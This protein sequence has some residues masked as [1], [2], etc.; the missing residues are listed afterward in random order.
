MTP[1]PHPRESINNPT[2]G[3]V[4]TYNGHDARSAEKIS[5]L[6]SLLLFTTTTA[7]TFLLQPPIMAIATCS[8]QV[9][10]KPIGRTLASLPPLLLSDIRNNAQ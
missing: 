9:K 1:L 7:I 2:M 8:L 4:N 5:V 6:L 10:E 3:C